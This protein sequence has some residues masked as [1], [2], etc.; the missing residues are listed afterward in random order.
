MPDTRFILGGVNAA[1]SATEIILPVMRG[2]VGIYMPTANAAAAVKNWLSGAGAA[3]VVGTPTYSAGYVTSPTQNDRLST[4]FA[5]T[6][7]S[8][9]Y[10]IARSAAAFSSGTTRPILGGIFRSQDGGFAG[11]SIRVTATPSAAPAASVALGAARDAAG[12][13]TMVDASITVANL[14]NW[15]MLCGRVRSG[16]V[17]DA[18]RLNDLTNATSA[19]TSA[20]TARTL[21]NTSGGTNIMTVGNSSSLS[22]GTCDVMYM[23]LFNVAHTDAEMN[24][25]GAAIRAAVLFDYGVTV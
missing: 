13:P 17:S 12:V 23:A 6:A 19:T 4:G 22:Y 7:E 11:T 5:E 9:L 14:S 1:A 16:A 21:A 2:A 3:T 25:N 10:I 20:S 24:L 15:T 18:R 8:S